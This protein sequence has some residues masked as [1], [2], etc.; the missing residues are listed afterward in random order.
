MW[1]LL[2]AV[3]FRYIIPIQYI[4]PP[5]I[6][7]SDPW[8]QQE[9]LSL[10]ESCPTSPGPSPNKTVNIFV[11]FS[12]QENWAATR[13]GT[14]WDSIRASQH[15]ENLFREGKGRAGWVDRHRKF[16]MGPRKLAQWV[17]NTANQGL[18]T[19]TPYG[20]LSRPVFKPWAQLDM[21][22]IPPP[23]LPI[24]SPHPLKG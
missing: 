14:M 17:R 8:A 21:L 24:P 10:A 2:K 5:R 22:S 13:P 19:S 9:A 15:Q 3:E 23:P 1:W 11:A 6:I 16:R 7:R 4:V 20:P 12:F 18:I